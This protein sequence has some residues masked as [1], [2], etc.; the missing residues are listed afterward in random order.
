ME[1]RRLLQFQPTPEEIA[2]AAST[3]LLGL[4]MRRS[5]GHSRPFGIALSGGRIAV[6]FYK[7]I[8]NSAHRTRLSFEGVHFF[9]ADERCVP[10]DSKENNYAVAKEHLL[11][12]LEIPEANIHRIRGEDDPA[13]A[14][15]DAEAE[16]CRVLPLASE[17]QP[18]I[19]LVILGMGEDGHVA[20]LFPAEGAEWV[21]D[22]AVYRP[23]IA[24]KPPPNRITLGYQPII[25]AREVWILASG[26]GKESAF[27]A[28]LREDLNLPAARVVRSRDETR[29]FQ[30]IDPKAI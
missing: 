21:R 8:V 2:R 14:S 24:T 7:Q 30:D 17:G 29:I 27:K 5:P 16:I 10:P 19:D 12:P 4:L 26:P 15:R 18:I 22:S 3:E 9:W 1:A 20:S 25:A 13:I 23:V 28:L 11:G 6:P